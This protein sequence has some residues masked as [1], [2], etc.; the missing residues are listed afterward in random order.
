M[1]FILGNYQLPM[2]LFVVD[3]FVRNHTHSDR[4]GYRW[5]EPMDL[6]VCVPAMEVSAL[7]PALND[8]HQGLAS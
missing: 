5:S 2:T 7:H 8:N 1:F 4:N 3:R 6:R